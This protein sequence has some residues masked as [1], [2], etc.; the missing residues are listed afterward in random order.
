MIRLTLTMFA[1][2]FVTASA[3]AHHS[4]APYDM[5]KEVVFTGT[6][7]KLDW[8]NP[9][10]LLTLETRGPDGAVVAQE[11][12]ASAVSQMRL[13]GLKREAL[14]PGTEVVVR[15]WPGRRR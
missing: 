2:G 7:T 5:T 9:H 1:A 3:S 12:E 8:N 6:V 13:L 15:A 11:I 4:R 10:I 14:E